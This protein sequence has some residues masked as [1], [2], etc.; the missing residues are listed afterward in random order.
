MLRRSDCLMQTIDLPVFF[1]Q[2][3]LGDINGD[4]ELCDF[5]PELSL[6]HQ[7]VERARSHRRF[8]KH[9]VGQQDLSDFAIRVSVPCLVHAASWVAASPCVINPE[10]RS[11]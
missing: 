6:L 2:L 7:H 8:I 11:L 3:L 4:I 1:L 5:R 10:A 9:A